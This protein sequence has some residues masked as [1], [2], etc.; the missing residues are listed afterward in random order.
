MRSPNIHKTTKN[1]YNNLYQIIEE[2]V[3]LKSILCIYE[4]LYTTNMAL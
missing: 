1:I 2:K 4:K 3:L